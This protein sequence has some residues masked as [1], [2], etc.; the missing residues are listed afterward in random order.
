M[1]IRYVDYPKISQKNQTMK[2]QTPIPQ[3][4]LEP[5]G[6]VC[7]R[8]LAII[9]S[10]VANYHILATGVH[11]NLEVAILE[12]ET[13]GIEQITKLLAEKSVESKITA[14]HLISHGPPEPST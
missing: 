9:D 4:K 5:V 10:G 14:V 11:P 12:P 13:D 8:Q 2:A 7:H 1:Y 3:E 6:A